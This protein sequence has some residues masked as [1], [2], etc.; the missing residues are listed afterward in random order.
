MILSQIIIAITSLMVGKIIAVYISPA[1]YGLYNIQFAIYIFV[2]SLLLSPLVEFFKST[3]KTLLQKIG[4]RFYLYLAIILIFSF[5]VIM[6]LLFNFKYE[7]NIYFYLVVLLVPFTLIYDLI[8]N[9]FNI[10]G[11]LNLFSAMNLFRTIGGLCFICLLYYLNY[12]FV[13]GS[14]VLWMVQIVSL[15]LGTL[16][17]IPFFKTKFS[18]SFKISFRSFI[19][20][21]A[22]F[23]WPLII[24]SFW[25]W[26]NNYSD[27]FFIENYLDVSQVGIYNINYSL[28]SKIFLTLNPLF[29]ILLVPKVYS[30]IS[31]EI[32]KQKIHNIVKFYILV[33]IPLLALVFFA[34]DFI[35]ALFL[36]QSYES[37]FYI[38]FWIAVAYF[39]LTLTFFYDIIFY[40]EGE[41]KYVLYS[42]M[43]AAIANVI[44]NLA[45]VPS[46]GLNGAIFSTLS[47][48]IIRFCIIRI[49][50]KKLSSIR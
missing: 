39:L 37:G 14:I 46:Y 21:Y 1:D 12:N 17:F 44:L 48:F 16:I 36:S 26:I 19:R 27:R 2:F 24:L 23:S 9:Y 5:S 3:A 47:S 29:M 34:N 38:I 25:S 49:Y 10:M 35:G 7:T 32:K 20:K 11:R 31:V 8:N 18:T 4:F 28:G 43:L 41:T 15:I 6:L 22:I 30:N 45:L 33:S 40:A 50:F 13:D 42:N